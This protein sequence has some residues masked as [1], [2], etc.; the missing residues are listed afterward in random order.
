VLVL[1]TR[2]ELG[3]LILGWAEP[4]AYLNPAGNVV[5]IENCPLLATHLTGGPEARN[6]LTAIS[7]A[8]T[9]PES[10][11]W[12]FCYDDSEEPLQ[13]DVHAARSMLLGGESDPMIFA[14]FLR[15]ILRGDVRVLPDST[16]RQIVV[17]Q[18]TQAIADGL[19]NVIRRLR[20]LREFARDVE[21]LDLVEA[22]EIT[23]VGIS[24]HIRGDGARYR[25]PQDLPLI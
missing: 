23:I 18:A 7:I 1:E 3:A 14:A 19:P 17:G 11:D 24:A 5:S 12:L 6:L 9:L 8:R 10:V 13:I 25:D 21:D 20:Q 2:V 15:K 4:R 22:L 16:W